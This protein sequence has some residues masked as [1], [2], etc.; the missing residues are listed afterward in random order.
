MKIK[1]FAKSNT[2]CF[3]SRF[4]I[5]NT[6]LEMTYSTHTQGPTTTKSLSNRER[7]RE[8]KERERIF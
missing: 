5:P 3:P 8:Q 4:T 2:V 1:V 6:T 7:K